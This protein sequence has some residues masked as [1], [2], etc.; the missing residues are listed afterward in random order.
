M[1]PKD[2]IKELA[3]NKK[4]EGARVLVLDEERSIMLSVNL[5]DTINIYLD[6]LDVY[7]IED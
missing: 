1:R 6:Y 5:S 3:S 7:M 4:Y 2:L